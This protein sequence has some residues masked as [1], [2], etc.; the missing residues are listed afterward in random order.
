M[1]VLFLRKEIYACLQIEGGGLARDVNVE[2]RQRWGRKRS[3]GHRGGHWFG[4]GR[5]HPNNYFSEIEE[6]PED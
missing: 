5:E 3:S 1:L 4:V 2:I 6:K